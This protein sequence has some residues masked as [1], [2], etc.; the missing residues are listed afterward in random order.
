MVQNYTEPNYTATFPLFPSDN[1]CIAANCC[2]S[3][4]A[5]FRRTTTRVRLKGLKR[6]KT[7]LKACHVSQSAKSCIHCRYNKCLSIGMSPSLLQG[8][9]LRQDDKARS[10]S[11][12]ES[13]EKSPVERDCETNCLQ[14]SPSLPTTGKVS[15]FTSLLSLHS[16]LF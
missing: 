10:P 8:Q 7:G 12:E 16:P 3:C 1:I 9:R 11:E 13:G 15:H 6:C 4:R 2:Y 5:F 14:S